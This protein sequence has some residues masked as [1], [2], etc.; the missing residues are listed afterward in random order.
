MNATENDTFKG[1]DVTLLGL[2][3]CC[4]AA[5]SQHGFGHDL[6]AYLHAAAALHL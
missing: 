3:Q 6:Y 5:S 4:K 2:Q 1:N